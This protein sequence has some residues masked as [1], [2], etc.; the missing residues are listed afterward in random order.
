M[1]VLVAGQGNDER[2]RIVKIPGTPAHYLSWGD[3]QAP[4]GRH[5]GY[6]V[7]DAWPSGLVCPIALAVLVRGRVS[8]AS[9]PTL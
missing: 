4:S 2:R 3:V 7:P 6:Y 9:M 1:A 8:E 5:D